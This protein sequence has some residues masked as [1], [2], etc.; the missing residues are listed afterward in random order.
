MN[1]DPNFVRDIIAMG[2]KSLKRCMQCAN[3]SVVCPLSPDEN[4]FPRKEMIWAQW[5]LKDRL[6]KDPDIWLCYN[7]GDCSKYCPRDAVPGQVLNA[8]RARILSEYI[9]PKFVGRTLNKPWSLPIFVILI[10]AL[11]IGG[12]LWAIKPTIPTGEI[13]T[14]E[15]IPIEYVEIPAFILGGWVILISLIGIWRFWL[16]ITDGGGMNVTVKPLEDANINVRASGGFM[17][18]NFIVAFFFVLRDILYHNWFKICETNRPRLPAHFLI[19]YGFLGLGLV[20]T[21]D[22]ISIYILGV[23]PLPWPWEIGRGGVYDVLAI[24]K[25]IALLSGAALVIGA[26]I[27]MWN[28][29]YHNRKEIGGYYDWFFLLV[30]FFVGVTGFAT[31][32]ARL[33]GSVSAYYLYVAHLYLVFMLLVYAPYSKFAHLLYRTVAMI[34][35]KAWKR[36]PKEVPVGFWE[37]L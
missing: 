10:P 28:R 5:G 1:V 30:I 32:I 13:A 18:M 22:F 17:G 24:F 9:W 21:I 20:A 16:A 14:S 26:C 6:I 31:T 11:I 19:F 4:P 8:I 37:G 23:H 12:I 27:A 7:C 33:L 36:E 3:C 29:L 2:G 25:G 34:Q 15:F 35:A